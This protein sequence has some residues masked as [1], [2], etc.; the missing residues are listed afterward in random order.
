MGLLVD[1]NMVIPWFA[2]DPPGRRNRSPEQVAARLAELD[3]EN[4]GLPDGP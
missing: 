4:L 2:L 1:R 3:A